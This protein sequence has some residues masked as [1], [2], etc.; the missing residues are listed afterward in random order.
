[1]YATTQSISSQKHQL[2]IL[3]NNAGI[4]GGEK[5]ERETGEDGYE[6]RF[7]VNYLA[8]FSLTNYFL[9]LLIKSAPSKIINVASGAQ[10]PI[11]FNDIMLTEQNRKQ[12]RYSN[13]QE[14]GRDENI[15]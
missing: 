9:P 13:K 15:F 2:H 1:M 12:R 10:E 11:N 4:G 5:N 3:I 7:T 8:P 14:H 6:L